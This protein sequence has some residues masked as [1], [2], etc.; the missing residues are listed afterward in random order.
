MPTSAANLSVNWEWEGTEWTM[1]LWDTAGQEALKTLRLVRRS[2]RAVLNWHRWRTQTR[3]Y[4]LWLHSD[5][6]AT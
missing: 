6:A 3:R 2:L 4:A 1:D 5:G